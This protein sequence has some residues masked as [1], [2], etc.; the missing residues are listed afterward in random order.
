M[1]KDLL[2]P[3][4]GRGQASVASALWPPSLHP[5]ER[6]PSIPQEGVENVLSKG[7]GV[8][9]KGVSSGR[10]PPNRAKARPAVLG[11]QHP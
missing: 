9:G 11:A 5:E 7:L 4:E 1:G 6:F 2:G 8:A 10:A 3:R